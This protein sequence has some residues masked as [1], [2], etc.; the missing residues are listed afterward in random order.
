V[1]KII[2]AFSFYTLKRRERR[3]PNPAQQWHGH[4]AYALVAWRELFQKL[5]GKTPVPLPL[6]VPQR[7]VSHQNSVNCIIPQDST[8][9]A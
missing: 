2:E 4:L 3:A 5:T 7:A 1:L 8:I 9:T 6:C